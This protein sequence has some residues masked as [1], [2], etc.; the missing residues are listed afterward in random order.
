MTIHSY[1]LDVTWTGDHVVAP[2]NCFIARSVNF[3]VHH[4]ETVTAGSR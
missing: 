3:P 4:R 1:V 2:E